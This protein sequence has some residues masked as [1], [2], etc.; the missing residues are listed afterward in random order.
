MLY[1]LINHANIVQLISQDVLHVN[2]KILQ[3]IVSHVGVIIISQE[4]IAY[5]VKL[6]VEY[7]MHV[8]ILIDNAY[9]V[10]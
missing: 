8:I 10:S 6:Q 4:K 1:L 3:F 2:L 7:A 5:L 9:H